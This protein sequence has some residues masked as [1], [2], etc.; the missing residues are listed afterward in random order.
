[1]LV[2]IASLNFKRQITLVDA[3]GDGTVWATIQDSEGRASVFCIDGRKS[4]P[5]RSRLFDGGR[6]PK[7]PGCVLVELGSQE[8]GIAVSLLSQWL[9]SP[10]AFTWLTERGREIVIGSLLR[11]GDSS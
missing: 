7:K 4:S 8:E 5:T 6:H 3:Y 11:L 2:P 1:M 10:E 9:D